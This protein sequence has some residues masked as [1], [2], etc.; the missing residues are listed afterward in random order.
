MASIEYVGRV[1]SKDGLSMSAPKKENVLNFPRPR[2]MTALCSLLGLAK[3]FRGFVPNHSNIVRP[4]QNMIDHKARKKEA[5]IWTPAGVEAFHAIKLAISRCPLM[6]FLDDDSPIQLYTD[7][8]DYGIRGVLYQDVG[9]VWRPIAFVS[10]LLSSTQ[11]NWSTMRKEAY[12]IFHCCQQFDS[13][14]RDRKF[15][16]HTDHQNITFMKQSPSSMVSRWFIALQELDFE[17]KFVPGKDN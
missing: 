4:L 14:I 15:T 5:P 13:L 6:Y 1:V 7:A 12:A 11:I 9:Q 3:Y 16:I 17:V 10:K 2:T 8:S